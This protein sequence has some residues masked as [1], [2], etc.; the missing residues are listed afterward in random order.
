MEWGCTHQSLLLLVL[1]LWEQGVGPGNWG[2]EGY[3]CLMELGAETGVI[4]FLVF[5]SGPNEDVGS[6]LPQ[7]QQPSPLGRHPQSIHGSH[8]KACICFLSFLCE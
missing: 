6:A 5:P 8:R 4:H 2:P 3:S 1:P 7:Q